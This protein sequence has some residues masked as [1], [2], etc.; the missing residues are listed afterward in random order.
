V[1]AE[2]RAVD[3]AVDEDAVRIDSRFDWDGFGFAMASCDLDR[4]GLI[5]LLVSDTRFTDAEEP[6]PGGGFHYLV[7]GHSEV[8]RT[9][10]S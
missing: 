5:D 3:L 6:L 10:G 2:E 4:D 9:G 7:R 1:P 8:C